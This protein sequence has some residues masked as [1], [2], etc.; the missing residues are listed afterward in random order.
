MHKLYIN[1]SK[2][3]KTYAR[4]FD[5]CHSARYMYWVM[6]IMVAYIHLKQLKATW[7][8]LPQLHSA[9]IGYHD[10]LKLCATKTVTLGRCANA[11]HIVVGKFFN[12]K[13]VSQLINMHTATA[14]M[15]CAL[16]LQWGRCC[17]ACTVWSRAQIWFLI[18][19]Y[20]CLTFPLCS[21]LVVLL[22]IW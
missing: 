10:R 12:V 13:A 19:W 17:K 7:D 22:G 21:L 6:R 14:A 9:L 16:V 8:F 15:L 2:S 3:H 11:Y 4:D 1:S 20:C 18:L 5:G